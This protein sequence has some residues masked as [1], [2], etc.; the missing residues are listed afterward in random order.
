VRRI[1][2]LAALSSLLAVPLPS[3]LAATAEGP[4]PEVTPAS[5]PVLEPLPPEAVLGKYEAA[6]DGFGTPKAISFEYTVE[7][8]GE[9]DIE[10]HHRVYRSGPNER[11]ETLAVNDEKVDPPAVRIFRNRRDR[12]AVTNL[13]PR[14]AD[15]TFKYVGPHTIDKHIEYVFTATRKVPGPFNVV[16]ITIDGNRFLPTVIRFRTAQ[17]GVTGSGVITYAPSGRYWVPTSANATVLTAAR[18]SRERIIFTAYA[19]P[20]SLPDSTFGG[21]R[22]VPLPSALEAPLE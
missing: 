5:A 13:A 12:Y 11:D 14:V 6:L 16:W 2:A 15:Y 3:A 18:T 21:A 1:A 7:Q 20:P 19:F 22:P 17:S 8:A 10:Q 9:L 4:R